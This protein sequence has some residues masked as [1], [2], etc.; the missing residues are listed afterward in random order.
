MADY[1]TTVR[2]VTTT[3]KEIISNN[4]RAAFI[5]DFEL[6]TNNNNNISEKNY[7]PMDDSFPLLSSSSSSSSLPKL[8]LNS[9]HKLN[10]SKNT[11]TIQSSTVSKNLFDLFRSFSDAIFETDDFNDLN[12]NN[13]LLFLHYPHYHSSNSHNY[14]APG[15]IT[16]IL[17]NNNNHN[18]NNL[19]YNDHHHRSHNGSDSHNNKTSIMSNSINTNHYHHHT[20]H[21]HNNGLSTTTTASNIIPTTST[22]TTTTLKP[23]LNKLF[24]LDEEDDNFQPAASV[25]PLQSQPPSPPAPA[26]YS[27][28]SSNVPD[29]LIF[30][31][32]GNSSEIDEVGRGVSILSSI[33]PTAN[34]TITDNLFKYPSL[35]PSSSTSTSTSSIITSIIDPD[36]N[37]S[38][39]YNGSNNIFYFDSNCFSSPEEYELFTSMLC[40]SLLVLGIVYLTYGYR[41]FRALTFFLGLVFGAL[42]FHTICIAENIE[43]FST[44]LPYGHLLATLVAGLLVALFTTLVVYI[45]LFLVGIHLG[46]MSAIGILIVIYLLRPYYVA[47]QGPLSGLTLLIFFVALSLVGALKTIYFSK[48][49]LKL[50]ICH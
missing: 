17:N 43:I 14:R 10:D 13:D 27:T 28:I 7:D 49:N 35:L 41:C 16:T 38:M 4:T 2:T 23:I 45:G 48:G 30:D 34:L 29:I 25:P 24:N 15:Q 33:K 32:I 50:F 39:D 37:N 6:I 31:N 5:N 46:L 26:P 12:D 9:I 1:S 22:S 36:N 40:S 21:Y 3:A 44:L 42:L 20:H 19:N 8:P 18:H 11:A 47:L